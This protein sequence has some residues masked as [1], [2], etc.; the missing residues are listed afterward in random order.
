VAL[1]EVLGDALGSACV[2]L[3]RAA[4]LALHLLAVAILALGEAA[5]VVSD[6]HRWAGERCG[7]HS[8]RDA[9]DLWII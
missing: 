9:D 3:N 2:D 4:V 7:G 6:F 1:D 5:D 8:E